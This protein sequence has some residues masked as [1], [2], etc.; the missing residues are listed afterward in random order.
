ML[1]ERLKPGRPGAMPDEAP[2]RDE[3]SGSGDL[4]VRDAEQDRLSPGPIGAAAER[5]LDG[6]PSGPEGS[7]QGTT[8]AAVANNAEA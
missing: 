6:I 5:A 8:K 3:G 2:G 7:R 4:G 1:S